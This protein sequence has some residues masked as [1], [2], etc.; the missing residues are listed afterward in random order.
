MSDSLRPHELQ[1]VRLPCPSLS[2]KVCSNSCP[3]SQW[4]R[5]TISPSVTPFSSCPQ[6]FPA[7]EPFPMG[8]LFISGGQSIRAST[9]A[10]VLPMNI[11]GW[12]PLGWTDFISLQSKGLWRVFS[13]TTIQKHQFFDAQTSLWSNSGG[14]GR[15][16]VGSLHTSPG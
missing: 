14:R 5:P 15:A 6:S 12:S 10:S 11:Q 9:S 13:S 3:L 1:H 7:S 8:Q 2:P 16:V 4:C